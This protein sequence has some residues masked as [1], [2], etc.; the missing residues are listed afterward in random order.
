MPKYML[1]IKTEDGE[2]SVKFFDRLREADI[3]RFTAE[4]NDAYTEL[5]ERTGAPFTRE[6][7]I[8]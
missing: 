6:Y 4:Q 1:V 7:R 5:Y 2:V 3:F 8:I